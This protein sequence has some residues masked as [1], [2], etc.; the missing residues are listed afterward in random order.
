MK[1]TI[2]SVRIIEL[3]DDRT[4][5]RIEG[6]IPVSDIPEPVFEWLL[7]YQGIKVVPYDDHIFVA[8]WGETTRTGEDTYIYDTGRH[9]SESKAKCKLFKFL[10]NFSEYMA[11]Y[12]AQVSNVWQDIYMKYDYCVDREETHIANLKDE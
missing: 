7:E 5:C 12:Y 1:C 10:R 4:G 9:I 2:K 6:V 3:D 8:S 11:N